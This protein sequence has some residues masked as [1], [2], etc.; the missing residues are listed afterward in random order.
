MAWVGGIF[1][2]LTLGLVVLHFWGK[3]E[4]GWRE[5]L[6]S[7]VLVVLALASFG[8][9]YEGKIGHWLRNDFGFIRW[10]NGFHYYMGA[11]Y[12]EELGYFD[13][14]NC[15]LEADG[16]MR[17]KWIE[18]KEARNLSNYEIVYRDKLP[19]CPKELFTTIQSTPGDDSQLIRN[20]ILKS[21]PG[22]TDSR[23]ESFKQDLMIWQQAL[24]RH[25]GY[26]QRVV[27]D[28]GFNPA[29]VWVAA[30][31]WMV[32][33]V[34]LEN[35]KQVKWLFTLDVILLIL[36]YGYLVRVYGVRATATAGILSVLR[37][38]TWKFW[39]IL[40]VSF[41]TGGI[42]IL[43]TK[44][45]D[46]SSFLSGTSYWTAGVSGAIDGWSGIEVVDN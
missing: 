19:K 24:E 12:F 42:G 21:T 44:E 2:L 35:V 14:Y 18:A 40:V 32:N 9:V 43:Q 39:P 10:W 46:S 38:I 5:V 1:I 29:P 17:G 23:W 6:L 16:E 34:E 3:F 30:G 27:T 4:T 8:L 36:A 13:L 25:E 20:K 15:A 31:S 33:Q 7:W 37:A 22:V 11:K 28:K 45:G 26:F 41:G